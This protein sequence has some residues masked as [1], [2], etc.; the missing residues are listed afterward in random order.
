MILTTYA[1]VAL[2][3]P[4]LLLA[5][6]ISGGQLKVTFTSTD[7]VHSEQFKTASVF[8]FKEAAKP[9][10]K[11]ASTP[12]LSS[13]FVTSIDREPEIVLITRGDVVVVCVVV[14]LV[15]SVV[16]FPDVV[17]VIILSEVSGGESG[18]VVVVVVSMIVLV[19]PT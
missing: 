11:S 6:F 9:I 17:P 4:S 15:A 12:A 13:Q 18:A 14:V 5:P 19:V 8:V 1:A 3:V 10:D 2:A 16:V 7:T